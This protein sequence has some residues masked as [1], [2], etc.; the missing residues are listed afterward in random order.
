[1]KEKFFYS[2]TSLPGKL[3]LDFLNFKT[4]LSLDQG[5]S[6]DVQVTIHLV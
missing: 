2:K 4:V 1:M 6:I 5:V 3:N